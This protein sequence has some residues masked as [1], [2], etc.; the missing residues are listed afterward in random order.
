ML[1]L[2]H[3]FRTKE[4][5]ESLPE[6]ASAVA[7]LLFGVSV[8][9]IALSSRVYSLLLLGFALGYAAARTEVFSAT[10]SSFGLRTG[11]GVRESG[12]AS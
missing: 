2:I 5:G 7:I 12:R 3:A 9:L 11:E 8:A 1:E 6:V 4:F 10:A